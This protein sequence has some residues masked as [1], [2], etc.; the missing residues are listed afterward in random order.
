MKKRKI[1]IL[2]VITIICV[3]IISI[4][5]FNDIGNE[6]ENYTK[7]EIDIEDVKCIHI[8][9]IT[10]KSRDY[11]FLEKNEIEDIVDYLNTLEY[12]EFN[13]KDK[14]SGKNLRIRDKIGWNIDI[15]S[16][17]KCEDADLILSLVVSRGNVICV[18]NENYRLK[19]SDKEIESV[20]YVFQ[21]IY[22]IISVTDTY[23]K[24]LK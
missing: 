14:K 9:H 15:Y 20:N 21:K 22:R 11:T 8:Y 7:L 6:P 3:I 2:I 5:C 19:I 4:F 18:N 13:L 12:R 10:N 16:N 1:I 24:T 23:K 17:T